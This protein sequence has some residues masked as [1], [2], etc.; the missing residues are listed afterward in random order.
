MSSYRVRSICGSASE[1]RGTGRSRY[2]SQVHIYV[3]VPFCRRRCSYCDFAIAVRSRIPAAEFV[4]A[5]TAEWRSWE[6]SPVWRSGGE[7]ISIYFGGGTPSLLPPE[8]LGM[9]LRQ[10]GGHADS[11]EVTLE[12]NPDDVTD[13]AARAWLD[14]GFNRISLGAQSFADDALVW[15]HR[16]HHSGRIS[17]A[18]DTL[19][20]A[21]FANISLDLIF[22]L[23]A[24]V[25]RDWR[26]DLARTVSLRP[27]HIS[28][29]G[30][31]VEERTP[32]ARWID[33]GEC[34]PVPEERSAE[35]YLEAHEVLAAAGYVWY[36]V[37]NASLP[38]KHSRHNSAYWSRS[39]YLG[40]GPSAH[41][42]WGRTRQWNIR[43]WSAYRDALAARV[44]AVAGRESLSAEQEELE[45][46]Y[47][48]LRTSEGI[49]AGL[50]PNDTLRSWL[51]A[52]WARSAGHRIVL[53]PEGWL[54]LDSLVQHAVG[55][56]RVPGASA[57]PPG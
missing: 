48:G 13:A 21:G 36:E 2:L 14:A 33:R 40:L 55:K 23:P 19:R 10:L 49:D 24:G 29:Y 46:V 51:S 37:S 41:S 52:G 39:N 31:T 8:T 22:G 32:L 43:E 9:V 25:E 44:S 54:R 42:A 20:A 30:L 47:L 15:M 26:K 18:F 3:H 57:S 1:D 12:A 16:T 17:Q 27:E 4:E 5:I 35:E 50:L 34:R 38:G 7:I 45:R 6:G 56:S 28:L 11:C 53:T